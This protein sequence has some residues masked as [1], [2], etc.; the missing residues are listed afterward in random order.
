[1]AKE[2]K[3]LCFGYGYV[4]SRLGDALQSKD[5][6]VSGTSR[7]VDK[8]GVAIQFP[9]PEPEKT[10]SEITHILVSIPPVGLNDVVLANHRNQIVEAQNLKWIG[11]LGSTS[12]YGDYNGGWV[13]EESELKP[14]DAR[15][16]ARVEQE[17]GWLELYEKYNLSV[18]IFRLAGIYGPSR[19]QLEEVR[20]KTARRVHKEGQFFSRIHVDDIVQVL[21]ASIAKRHPGSVYNV[22]DDEPAP[23]YEVVDYACRLL[24]MEPP[25][26]VEWDRAGLSE[27]GLSF[28]SSNR[29]V[30]NDK[31][32]RELGVLLKYPTYREGL[33][34]LMIA[35]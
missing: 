10:L 17:R 25:A 31:I 29:R 15:H 14:V 33:D 6:A 5:F 20:R 18:H 21:S 12:V 34:S 24:G 23:S 16:Q 13:D 7:N 4:A 26:M 1:M 2:N 30:R 9:L 35:E 11:L 22:C 32:K 27:M 3:L 8:K 28:Y 19:N